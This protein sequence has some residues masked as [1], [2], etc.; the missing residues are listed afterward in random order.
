MLRVSVSGRKLAFPGACCCCRG[1]A[2]SS[3][4]ATATRTTGK[5][6]I[7][8]QTQSW[9]FPCC[10]ACVGHARKSKTE[11]GWV[12]MMLIGFISG[13]FFFLGPNSWAG[14]VLLLFGAG[15]ILGAALQR[16]DARAVMK[17]TCGDLGP[18]VQYLGWSGTFHALAFSNTAY[19]GL[20]A[21]ENRA[22]LLD[23]DAGVRAA[24][25]EAS[26]AVAA[27]AGA[28]A[29]ATPASSLA[30]QERPSADVAN[31]EELIHGAI[32]KIEK[33][34]GPASRRSALDAALTTLASKDARDRLLLEA[35]RIEVRA[36]LDKVDGLKTKSAKKRHL[37]EA[38]ANIRADQVPDALQQREIGILEE[39]LREVDE[40]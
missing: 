33:Q 23:V 9:T 8:T 34:K 7:R 2:D 28:R 3:I 16:R 25:A 36:V 15:G 30:Q 19:A 21:L 20:F 12:A 26:V 18:P 4:L 17:P 38:L 29:S 22:R 10:A 5:R 27:E 13:P 11:S 6:V 14:F 31:E 40:A 37:D 39:A 1:D 32:V 24:M 35:S